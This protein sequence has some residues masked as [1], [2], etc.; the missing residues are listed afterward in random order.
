[1]KI[2]LLADW[3]YPCDHQF[4]TNVYAENF[5][6]RG[7]DVTWVM[8]PDDPDQKRTERHTWNGSDVYVLPKTAFDPVRNYLR[9]RTG[10]ITENALFS[11]D[12]EFAD[13]EIVHVRNDLP[14]G[15]AAAHIANTHDVAFAHQISHLKAESLVEAYREGFESRAAWVKGHLG[16]RLRRVVADEADLLLPISEAMAE[17]LSRRGYNTPMEVLPTGTEVSDEVPNGDSFESKYSVESDHVLLY[18]GSMSPIRRLEF[19]FDVLGE[20]KQSHDVELFMLGGRSKER[21]ERLKR[22]ASEAGVSSNVT[23]TGWITDRDEIDAAVAAADI[24]LSPLPIDSVLRMN[25]PI[26]TLE[27]MSLATPVVASATPDQRAVL[28][29]SD[30]GMAVDY[31]VGQFSAAIEKLLSSPEQRRQMGQ[32]GRDYVSERR[33]FHVLTEKVERMYESIVHDS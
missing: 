32:R 25:A 28:E 5:V 8:R 12:I 13:F 19:L 16:K 17:Y 26:K 18:M 23:F 10:R 4:L 15:L 20:V 31:D 29:E 22:L 33:N 30:A 9:Y 24:G 1:M 14:M 27:Y 21:R 11:T 3:T 7:H 6:E 2:L